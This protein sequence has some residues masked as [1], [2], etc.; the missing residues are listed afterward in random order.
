VVGSLDDG[1]ELGA[2]RKIVRWI[3]SRRPDGSEEIMNR[4]RWKVVDLDA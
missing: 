1:G 2:C 4:C 3:T